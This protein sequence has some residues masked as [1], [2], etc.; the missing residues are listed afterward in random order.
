MER[1]CTNC[2]I[3]MKNAS[4]SSNGG[5]ALLE[6]IKRGFNRKVCGVNAYVCPKC[7]YIELIAEKPEIFDK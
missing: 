5:Y 7:G 2:N 6:E 1:K 4:L 3:E